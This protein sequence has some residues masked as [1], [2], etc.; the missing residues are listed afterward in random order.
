MEHLGS[1]FDLT[2]K[3]LMNIVD[4]AIEI[5]KNPKRY[6]SALLNKN[7]VMLFEKPSTRT[8]VSFEAGMTQLGGH[9]IY[10]DWNTTQLKKAALKDE[11]KCLAKY[12]DII[13]A[14]V[15]SQETIEGMIKHSDKP[16]INAL[17]DKYHPCQIIAD[18]MTIKEKFGKIGGLKL[19]YI[20]DGNNVCNSLIIGCSMVGMKITV[21]TPKGYEPLKKAVD[22]GNV[23]LT[24]D[25]KEASKAADVVYTDT[26]VSMGQEEEKK[27][28]LKDFKGFQ[29]DKGLLGKA[30]FM[31]CLPAYRGIEVTDQVMD[32]KQSIIFDQAENR[33]HAQKAVIL[34][35]LSKDS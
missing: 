21:A 23:E 27:K 5:K 28:R 35:L 12:S 15:F 30:L 11:I 16:I 8:R 4:K 25:P 18:I 6:H 10:L 2:K 32:S 17:S 29:V 14:R 22:F 31:H 13:M 7:L 20:G 33:M 26:W 24:K 19:A 34:Q 9:A 1:L 3:E